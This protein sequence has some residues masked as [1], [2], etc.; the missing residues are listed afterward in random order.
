MYGDGAFVDWLLSF[1]F[2]VGKLPYKMLV[3]NLFS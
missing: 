1:T 2:I 3:F